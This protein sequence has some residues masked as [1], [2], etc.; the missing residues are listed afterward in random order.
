[1]F[2]IR[3]PLAVF[4]AISIA[5]VALPADEEA[6]VERRSVSARVVHASGDGVGIHA[7]REPGEFTIPEGTTARSF[8]YRF[9]DPSSGLTLN[10]LS[11]SNIYSVTE[12]RYITEAAGNPD[13]T[14]PPGKYKF[15]VGGR[16]GASGTLSFDMGPSDDTSVVIKDDVPEANLPRDGSISLVLW[17]PEGPTYKFHWDLEIKGGIVTG[18]GSLPN[19]PDSHVENYQADY[20]PIC[21]GGK[22]T[23]HKTCRPTNSGPS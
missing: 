9:H 10:K 23:T 17:S 13:L 7:K 16:P 20:M 2:P 22:F 3:F 12:K 5:T 14:L 11:G 19:P 15:V 1:M 18:T 21:R 6:K 4:V 8:K